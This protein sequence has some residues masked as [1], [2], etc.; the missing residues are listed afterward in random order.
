[1]SQAAESTN[2][3][4]AKPLLEERG[5]IIVIGFFAMVLGMFMSVLDIQ[6]V[7][8]SLSQIQA[9]LSA[10]ASEVSWVQTS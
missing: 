10:S 6:I 7:A 2:A 1:M 5:P 9:G 3:M 4:F 8:S